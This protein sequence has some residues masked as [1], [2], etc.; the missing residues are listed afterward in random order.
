MRELIINLDA[1]VQNYRTM[2]KRSGVRAMAVVKADAYGHGMIPVARALEAA[3]V[4]AFGVADVEE[5]L[6]LR[7]AGITAPVLAWLH[8][9]HDDFIEAVARDID[10]GIANVDQLS[11]AAAAAKAVGKVAHLHL[12][13]DTGL[14][15]NGSTEAKWPELIAAA[16]TASNDGLIEVTGIFSHLS[17][18]SEA[19]DRAQIAKFEQALKAA[20]AAGLAYEVAHLTASDG[21]ISYPEAHFDM[22]RIGIAL[23]GLDPFSSHRSAEFGLKPAMTAKALVSQVKRVP[24]GQGVSYGYL[25]RTATESNLVL[26][27]IGYAEGLPRNATG[28]ASAM[29]NGKSYPLS[30]RVA[31]DQFVLDVGDDEVSVGDEVLLFGDPDAG[32]PSVDSL[33]EACG[34]INYEIVTRMGGRFKRSYIGGAGA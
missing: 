21:S 4:D 7:D 19:E 9:P 34:T 14:G 26:V 28:H 1:I 13:I 30:S 12:K 31:M 20:R 10:L 25:H 32:A 16:K 17:T 6:T 3:G 27:P 18:T 5:A 8:N 33:A 22:V 2:K 24:A 23:Y 15:R 11:R 29:I